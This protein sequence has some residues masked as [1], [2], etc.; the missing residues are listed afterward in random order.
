MG[1]YDDDDV[2]MRDAREEEEEEEIGQVRRRRRRRDA[3]AGTM[4]RGTFARTGGARVRTSSARDGRCE[5]ED[6]V[7]DARG[8]GRR[9]TGDVD[10]ARLGR[11]RTGR[12]ISETDERDARRARRRT[13][14]SSSARFSRRRVS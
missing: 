3:I 6:D 14:G 10:D 1:V 5:G 12:A 4:R 8:R 7:D 13:P 2:A 9:E 11:S